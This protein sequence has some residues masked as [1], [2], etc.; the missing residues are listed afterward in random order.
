MNAADI[1]A[2]LEVEAPLNLPLEQLRQQVLLRAVAR[3]ADE[4]TL[5]GWL[6]NQ[7][8]G[9][10]RALAVY[11]ANAAASAQSALAASYP[12]VQAL[13]GDAPFANLARVLWHR[14]PPTR[15][16]LAWFGSALPDFMADDEQLADFP[17]LP[18]V[19]RLDQALAQAESAADI[20]LDA[21]SLA[22]L[23]DAEPADITLV[24]AAGAAVLP[25]VWPIVTLYQAHQAPRPTEPRP[26]TSG[27][28]Q[29]KASPFAK[30]RAAL[31]AGTCETAFV[32]RAG[33]KARVVALSAPESQF[34]SAL[35]A[36]RS[37]ATA[38]E[39]AGP[40]FDFAACLQSG[41]QQGWLMGA[42]RLPAPTATS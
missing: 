17:Y 6:R 24:L 40:G 2:Q 10:R 19:A 16:D 36:S 26:A 29:S 37:L 13:M 32:W 21:A 1:E 11:Q 23:S 42:R 25:S 22:L 14:R 7:P 39:G 3:L 8:V 30:A 15:G 38:L 33:W 35:L 27:W 31:S 34:L 18:D 28:G 20:T 4:A 5:Q 12:T 41:L 9:M